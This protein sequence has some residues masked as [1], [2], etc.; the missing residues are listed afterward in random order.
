MT[1]NGAMYRL[2]L[3]VGTNSIGWA[4]IRLDEKGRPCGLLDMG[5]R[6]FPD[7]RSPQSKT[8]NA[9]ERRLARGQRRRRDRYLQRRGK[10]MDSLIEFGLMP[11]CEVDRRRLNDMDPYRLR[12]QAL[13]SRLEPHQ[14]GRALFHL[15]Q[16]RG[17]KSNR[18]TQGDDESD[19]SETREAISELRRQIK[20][21]GAR[22]LGEFQALRQEQGQPLRA[23]QGVGLYPER[24]MYEAEFDELRKAQQPHHRLSDDQWDVLKEIIFFQRPLKPVDPGWCLLEKGEKR[25]AKALPISQEFRMLQEVNNLRVRVGTEPERPLDAHE[26]ECAMKRLRSG[27]DIALSNGRDNIPAKPTKDLGLPSDTVFNLAAGGRKSIKGDETAGRLMKRRKSKTEPERMLFGIRWLEMPLEE[28]NE[29]VRFLLQAEEP[30][31]VHRKA[32]ADWNLDTVQ[33]E[34]LANIPLTDGYG[35]LSEKAMSKLLPHLLEGRVY[36]DAALEAGYPSHSDFRNEEAHDKLPYYG[37]VLPRAVVG[38]DPAKDPR[39]DGEPARHGRLAN[40]TVHIGLNQLRR[41]VN[42]LINAYGKPEEI[43]VEVARDLKLGREAKA[44]LNQR[45]IENRKRNERR[46]EMLEAM[47]M[48]PTPGTIRKLRLWEQQGEP[49]ARVCPYTGRQLSVHMV[50]SSQT[51]VDHILPFSRT[52]DNSEAN[53]VVCI[54]GANRDKGDRS[55]YEAFGHNPGEYD[56]KAIQSNAVGLPNNKRWRFDKDAMERYE[57]ERGFLDRQLSETSY[58]SRTARAYLAYLYDEKGE[59]RVRVRAVPG[60][61]TALLRRGWGLE[62][63]LRVTSEGVVVRGKQR[64]DHR[65]HAIDA[66]VVANTTQGLLQGFASASASRGGVAEDRMAAVAGEVLPWEGFNRNQLRSCLDRLVVSYKPDHGS[67]GRGTTGQLHNETAYGLIEA[68][69]D[70]T[71]RVVVRRMLS[72]VKRRSDFDSV[73]DTALKAALIELWDGIEAKSDTERAAVFAERAQVK[74]VEVG[75]KYQQV[76]RVRMTDKQRVIL[77]GRDHAGNPYKGYLPGGNEFAAVW[78]MRDGNW[79]MVV[80]P[81]FHANQSDF[82]IEEFRPRTSQGKHKGYPDPVAKRLMRIRIDDMGALGEGQDLRIVRVRKISNSSKRTLVFLDNHNEANVASRVA[83]KELKEE[84][85]SAKQ[86]K[87]AGFR[88]VKVD[89]I[90]QLNDPGPFQP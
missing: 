26:R 25:A 17:F 35:S 34:T 62:G 57:G 55:P 29:I 6:V 44:N 36:S 70:G 47:G 51:E 60:R 42:G 11:T 88:I 4:A 8:S 46:R 16:R 61:M 82:D 48:S 24:A 1:A 43:V 59:G 58:L 87:E 38:A 10:L 2:G 20:A 71:S 86:L 54:A 67:V 22:T 56:Y 39:I 73:R 33:A 89:E 72:D 64:D 66:F 7:G 13:D 85:Y 79:Q 41:V 81:R 78:K 40:P 90:G 30:E 84:K 76:R 19:A 50:L 75:G 53:M 21:S 37:V 45:Q 5:V 63:I 83:K 28:R 14:L 31:D 15:G 12:A 18:K 49:Q 9:V 68:N 52:L 69:E 27:K 3:D 65:H 23:R 80:V 32:I 74:G 77:I